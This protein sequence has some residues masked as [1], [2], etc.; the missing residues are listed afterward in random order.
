MV[1]VVVCAGFLFHGYLPVCGCGFGCGFTNGG[2]GLLG[3]GADGAGFAT[4]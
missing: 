2:C 1:A 3:A 4:G